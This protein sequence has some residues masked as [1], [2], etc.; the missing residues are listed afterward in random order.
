MNYKNGFVFD[1]GPHISFTKQE[2]IK[3]LLAKSVQGE[4]EERKF[5]VDNYWR[6]YRIAHPVQCYLRDLPTDLVVKVISDFIERG[7]YENV[8]SPFHACGNSGSARCGEHSQRTYADWLLAVYGKTFAETFPMTY[9]RKYHTAPMDKLTT[10]WVGPRMYRPTLEEMLRGA[11]EKQTPD[12]HYIQ[13]YRYPSNGGFVK[14]IEGFA[15]GFDL[16]LSHEVIGVD[17]R[18][19][20]LRFSNGEI[21]P[22]SAVISSIPLPDLIPKIDGV[23]NR[24]V[25]ASRRLA[26]STVV[27]VNVGLGRENISEAATTYFYDEDIA[28][29]RVS[30]PHMFSASNTPRGCGSIQAEVYVSEKYKPLNIDLRAL[31]ARVIHDLRRSSF[32]LEGDEILMTDTVVSRFANVIYDFDRAAAVSTVHDFLDDVGIY[33]CGRF[34]NWD[35][36]WT[37][38]AFVSGEERARH[39]VSVA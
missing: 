14:Y 6:G 28:F 18:A 1:E 22:Y 27:L 26:F 36:S 4:Y 8:T 21:H 35:H 20:M 37:D 29:S 11:I 39:V 7:R 16:R 23:P 2:R 12:K 19:K 30:L 31:E 10:D 38:E 17:P 9:G 5:L 3:E 34:G 15:S 25:E 24:V 13:M 32:I 33:Y